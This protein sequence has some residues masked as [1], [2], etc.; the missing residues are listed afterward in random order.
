MRAVEL[1]RTNLAEINDRI[2]V[3]AQRSGREP[4][5]VRLVAVSKGRSEQEILQAAEVGLEVFGENRVEEALPK[6]K[7]LAADASMEWHMIGHLQSRKAA[8]VPGNFA[9]MHSLD[10][11]KIARRLQTHAAST[12]LRQPVLLECNV[13]GETSKGG[14]LLAEQTAW[15]AALKDFELICKMPNLE[16][17]GLMTMAPWVADEAVL[18]RTF[19]R[20]RRL[21]DFLESALPG[22]WGELS[23]GM[24][25][26][27]EIAVEEG[28]TLVRIGR[29]LFDQPGSFT[30]V[31]PS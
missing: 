4:Q 1:I 25:D 20:L 6:I 26:D 27:Y 13:S 16:V 29:A 9:L 15:D 2:R 31:R 14:W 30:C 24:T 28:S 19:S 8:S 5:A 7:N 17:R 12:G 3:A 23:M 22:H 18:R 11:L 10:R 21:R